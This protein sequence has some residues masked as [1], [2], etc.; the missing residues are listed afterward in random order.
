MNETKNA[1]VVGKAVIEVG[2][3]PIAYYSR[4]AGSTLP[5]KTVLV[6][7]GALGNAETTTDMCNE[8]ALLRPDVCVFQMD[9]PGHGASGG[10]PLE[11]ISSLSDI[12]CGF[13]K[14]MQDSAIFTEGLYVF[15]HS[16]GGT[17]AAKAVIDGM[18]V[19]KLGLLQSAASWPSMAPFSEMSG[20]QLV[21]AFQQM[22]IGEFEAINNQERTRDLIARIPD[23]SVSAAACIADIKALQS[24]DLTDMLP[25]LDVP[26][27]VVHSGT[28][29]TATA[30]SSKCLLAGIVGSL[31]YYLEFG[32][33]TS[34]IGEYKKVA[35][36]IANYI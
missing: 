7:H 18:K 21:A 17:V 31:S 5:E 3:I 6:L 14:A 24:C 25:K 9:N 34:V 16:M 36:C 8:L 27:L 4:Y 22:M 2:G 20:D 33:H 12:V 11:T 19:T 29:M 28:D 23:M 32:T 26:T 10:D 35:K 30:E 15:G 13:V 1:V